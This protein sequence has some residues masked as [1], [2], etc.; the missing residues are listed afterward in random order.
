M[1]ILLFLT[2]L[3]MLPMQTFAQ[4][5]TKG[6]P[7][8]LESECLMPNKTYRLT[9]NDYA[10]AG[11]GTGTSMTL[12]DWLKLKCN[13]ITGSSYAMES[14]ETACLTEYSFDMIQHGEALSY[15]YSSNSA[16]GFM[17]DYLDVVDIEMRVFRD[18]YKYDGRPIVW[19][20]NNYYLMTTGYNKRKIKYK[21]AVIPKSVE[22]I[23][24]IS[25]IRTVELSDSLA[26]LDSIF[27]PS[28]DIKRSK[29]VILRIVSK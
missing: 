3:G 21:E 27:K 9:E 1:K 23:S 26:V 16:N 19:I 17:P 6:E 18:G 25:N 20:Y 10:I 5:E 14:G 28:D 11:K 7:V 8:D 24:A 29:P 13:K 2:L 15:D 4:D 22:E 12:W